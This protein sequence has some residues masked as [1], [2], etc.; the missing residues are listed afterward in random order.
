LPA[1]GGSRYSRLDA[2]WCVAMTIPYVERR[3]LVGHG[4]CA[5]AAGGGAGVGGGSAGRRGGLDG[6]VGTGE[7]RLVARGIALAEGLGCDTASRFGALAPGRSPC[8]M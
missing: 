6:L 5:G 1:A 2:G 3:E 7:E 4:M 8:A